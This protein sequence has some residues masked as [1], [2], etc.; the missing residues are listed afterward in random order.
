MRPAAAVPAPAL[1]GDRRCD[2]PPAAPRAVSFVR[3][4]AECA[5]TD[6]SSD[7]QRDRTSPSNRG[8]RRARFC[9]MLFHRAAA[10]Q[11]PAS[12]RWA[13]RAICVSHRV[14]TPECRAAQCADARRSPKANVRRPWAVRRA[15]PRERCGR[16]HRS[17]R[18]RGRRS[19][20][21]ADDGAAARHGRQRFSF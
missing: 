14:R 8:E 9:P 16:Q 10:M 18:A 19:A 11:S 7:W 21:Q 1:P 2:R 17:P 12:S 13:S 3:C 15:A 20:A 5:Q 4:R 6:R